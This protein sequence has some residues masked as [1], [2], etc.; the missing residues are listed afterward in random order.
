MDEQEAIRTE[1]EILFGDDDPSPVVEVDDRLRHVI[2]GA[3][4]PAI[5]ADAVSTVHLVSYAGG[6]AHLRVIRGD[7]ITSS[8]VDRFLDRRDQIVRLEHAGI[9]R[10]YD[11]GV[12][13][14]GGGPQPFLLTERI[15]G[16]TLLDHVETMALGVIAR[17]EQ[18]LCAAHPRVA[19]KERL[20]G[21]DDRS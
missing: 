5:D 10:V 11:A 9:P 16:R 6:S 13:E 20:E 1:R 8:S 4:R 21:G 14:F 2:T 15:E 7:A 19:G 17:L 18:R 3:R 12:V